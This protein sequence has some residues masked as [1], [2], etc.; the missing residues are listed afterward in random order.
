MQDQSRNFFGGAGP[1]FCTKADFGIARPLHLY[2]G[3]S[4]VLGTCE[5]KTSTSAMFSIICFGSVISTILLWSHLGTIGT[6]RDVSTAQNEHDSPGLC[7]SDDSR[8]T[9]SIHQNN[10]MTK[11]VA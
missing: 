2:C 8:A 1:S 9:H 11:F 10:Q 4:L 7:G 3:L 6:Q 5:Y